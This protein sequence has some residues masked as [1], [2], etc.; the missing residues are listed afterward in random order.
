MLK[1]IKLLI[2]NPTLDGVVC[3]PSSWSEEGDG[4]VFCRSNCAC[5]DHACLNMKWH[6]DFH[7][8]VLLES[9][10]QKLGCNNKT[11]DGC[12]RICIDVNSSW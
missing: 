2:L 12:H 1:N 11:Q 5:C 3:C 6:T 9:F 10:L 7:S 8:G 4:N